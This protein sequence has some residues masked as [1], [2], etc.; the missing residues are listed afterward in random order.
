M[1]D[2]AASQKVFA[3]WPTPVTISGFEIGEKILTGI[4]LIN[5]NSIQNSPVKDAFQIALTKDN[6]KLGRNSW[7]ESAV[8]VAVR[9][10]E[11][12]F[13]FRKVNFEIK[14]DGKDVL[15][16]GEKFTYLQFKQTPEEIGKVIENL[17]MHQPVK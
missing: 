1:V 7:D 15:I 3:D 17:M 5:N 8:L 11:P 12:Y 2:A 13:T 4:R 16:P 14:N 9:G 6:N 10:I